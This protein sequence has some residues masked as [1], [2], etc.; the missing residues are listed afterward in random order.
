[1]FTIGGLAK[2]EPAGFTFGLT[3]DV[4]TTFQGSP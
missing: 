4:L 3:K 2:P 1:M